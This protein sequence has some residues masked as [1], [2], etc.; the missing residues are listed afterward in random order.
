MRIAMVTREFAPYTGRPTAV[1][2]PSGEHGGAAAE[3]AAALVALG[4]EVHA[5]ALLEPGVD[6]EARGLARRLRP[7]TVAGPDGD[8]SWHRFDGLTASGVN[9]HLLAPPA[10]AGDPDGCEERAAILGF[11]RVAIE[12][13]HSLGPGATWCC[14]W[15]PEC[16]AVAAAGARAGDPGGRVLRHLLVLAVDGEWSGKLAADI[17]AHERVVIIGNAVADRWRARSPVF[18]RLLE[19][20][21]LAVFPTPVRKSRTLPAPAKADRKAALQLRHG[22]PVRAD[23]PLAAVTDGAADIAGLLARLLRQDVQLAAFAG[24]GALSPLAARYPDRLLIADASLS[25]DDLFAAADIAVISGDPGAAIRAMSQGAVPVVGPG[26]AEG[27]VDLAPDLSSGSGAVAESGSAD[28]VREAFGRAVG[29]YRRGPAFFALSERI[30]GFP[31]AWPQ[32][33]ARFAQAMTEPVSDPADSTPEP[34]ST[35]T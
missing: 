17:E 5:I 18:R 26:D 15:N 20:G 6:T 4:H 25:L 13:A 11:P 21:R 33:A 29:A 12:L 23:L 34:P 2:D 1:R 31:P 35:G 30:Q 8:L 19:E 24:S 22:L 9:A 32:V 27:V 28:A 7:L 14:A 3:L 10:G 16:A